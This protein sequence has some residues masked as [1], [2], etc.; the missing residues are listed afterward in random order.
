MTLANFKNKN[1]GKKRG[2][3]MPEFSYLPLM[4]GGATKICLSNLPGRS[5]AASRMS[6]LFVAAITTTFAWWVNPNEGVRGVEKMAL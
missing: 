6:I 4:S 1:S 3:I 2:N 5:K